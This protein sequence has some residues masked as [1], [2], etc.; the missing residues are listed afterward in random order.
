MD[1]TGQQTPS[2]TTAT[3]PASTP[4]GTSVPGLKPSPGC[5]VVGV[6]GSPSS[7]DAVTWAAEQ[8]T[9]DHRSLALVH[10]YTLDRTLWVDSMGVDRDIM[11]VM[12]D[13]GRRLL[14]EA[15]VH[16]HE[17]HPDLEV[18]EWLYHA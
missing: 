16:A 12:A 1:A 3:T 17:T 4:A 9:R 15:A 14:L 11:K 6:D 7:R 13:D 18:H 5:I 2:G 8:A 10:A